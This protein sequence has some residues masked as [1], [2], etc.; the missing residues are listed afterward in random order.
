M[1]RPFRHRGQP[2][3]PAPRLRAGHWA[4][5]FLALALLSGLG[6]CGPVEK[7]PDLVFIS[8]N[9][10]STLDPPQAFDQASGRVIT[11]IFE[12]LMRWNQAGEA[13][14]G[15]AEKPPTVD[16]TGLVYTFRLRPEARWS[17]GDPITANDFLQ[18]WTRALDPKNATENAALY[19][20]IKNA[21]AFNEEK[22]AD[23]TQLGLRTP[24]PHTLEV[25]LEAPTPYFTD[26][27][28]LYAFCPVHVGSIN[29]SPADWWKPG[30]LVANGPYLLADWRINY[31]LLLKKN[32]LYWDAANVPLETVELRTV[33]NPITSLNY[34]LT[35]AADLTTDKDGVPTTLVDKLTTEPFFHSGP[36]LGTNFMRFN[37]ARSGPFQD[38]RVRR[39]FGLAIDRDRLVRVVTRMGE[40]PAHSLTPPGCGHGYT[41]PQRLPLTDIAT[42][43]KLLAEAGFPGGKG[44]PLVSYLYPSR[45]IDIALA[46]ELQAMWEN[47]LGVRVQPQKQ[48]WKVYLDS[49]KKLN[50][51]ICRSSWVGDYNDPNTFLEQFTTGNGN[52]RTGYSH[53]DYDAA[54]AAAGRE[55]DAARR[56]AILTEAETRLIHDDAVVSPVYHYVGVQFYFSDE[57]AGVQANLVDEHPFRCMKRLRPPR[58]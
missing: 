47:S 6:A 48:E 26:L 9:E 18:A 33:V 2:P 50:Y 20:P 37:C 13:E 25:T 35:G 7:R 17:N 53:P 49:M 44:F 23:P 46:I 36:F 28:A 31:R 38:P 8:P 15:I 39:A 40:P 57:I 3:R 52:N 11:S 41:P 14:P 42:A 27:C 12:G 43:R 54:I 21:R 5:L 55:P 30:R 32:P 19:Y 51:D 4:R 16:P 58:L 10:P 24:D 34:F 56:N 1:G 29:A 22:L 45:D